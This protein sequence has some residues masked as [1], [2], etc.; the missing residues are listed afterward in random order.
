MRTSI[1]SCL[2]SLKVN[3]NIHWIIK[4][5]NLRLELTKS[6]AHQMEPPSPLIS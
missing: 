6:G 1:A 2:P 3:L 4:L 5:F